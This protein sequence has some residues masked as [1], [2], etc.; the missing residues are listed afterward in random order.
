VAEDRALNS[1]LG[2]A[3][4][5]VFDFDGT[6]TRRDTLVPFLNAVCGRRQVCMAMSRHGVRVTRAVAGLG[7]EAEAK[8]ALFGR[9]LKGRRVDEVE[10]EIPAFTA[11]LLA[12]GMRPEMLARVDWHLAEGHR[13]I[14]VS[15]SPELYVGPIARGLGFTSVI[16][17]RLE[18]DTDGRLTGRLLGANVKGAEKV[19]RLRQEVGN[20]PVGWAYGNSRGDRE[21]LALARQ[22]MMVGKWARP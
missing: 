17:T 5:A 18:V 20:V 14:V 21:L 4:L 9:L 15:A 7:G 8:Q 2:D 3:G 11:E 16:A 10:A 22:P 13:L 19:H 6:L 1:D 12:R